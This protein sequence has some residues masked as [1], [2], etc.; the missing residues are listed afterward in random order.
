MSALAV[1]AFNW[2]GAGNA[3]V[4]PAELIPASDLNEQH[5]QPLV[6]GRIARAISRASASRSGGK[7]KRGSRSSLPV[8]NNCS[9]RRG[10][11]AE[12]A[13]K[14]RPLVENPLDQLYEPRML[15][16][17]REAERTCPVGKS[18]RRALA[19]V[20]G[21]IQLYHRGR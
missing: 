5:V 7:S 1:S 11:G 9:D 21:D 10:H 15:L 20:A 12:P 3:H 14:R 4:A 17:S 16:R 18:A 8:S 13:P 6:F 19:E 2:S